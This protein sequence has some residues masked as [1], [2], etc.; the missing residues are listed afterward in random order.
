MLVPSGPRSTVHS[1]MV[2]KGSNIFRTSSSVCCFPSIPTKSFRSSG[3]RGQGEGPVQGL[4]LPS[5]CPTLSLQLQ[6]LTPGTSGFGCERGDGCGVGTV[7]QRA[8]PVSEG[9]AFLSGP[10]F[11]HLYDGLNPLPSGHTD[12]HASLDW[13]PFTVL[14]FLLQ[15]GCPQL[16]PAP[17]WRVEGKGLSPKVQN[18]P[19]RLSLSAGFT[20]IGL[21][22]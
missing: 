15:K 13:E 6:T 8:Y 3:G 20:W 5:H 21:F 14:A 4:R 22:I 9:L 2:P 16:L 19:P 7:T 18:L 1:S 17:A 12:S 11:C 10:Q